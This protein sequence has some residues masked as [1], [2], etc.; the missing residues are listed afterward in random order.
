MTDSNDGMYIRVRL[1]IMLGV[2]SLIFPH[3]RKGR[4]QGRLMNHRK[5]IEKFDGL[6]HLDFKTKDDG[7]EF[8]ASVTGT[9]EAVQK[10][11]RL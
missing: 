11:L 10:A 2:E 8:R 7:T 4:N 5:D 9:T 3:D 1:F 6:L